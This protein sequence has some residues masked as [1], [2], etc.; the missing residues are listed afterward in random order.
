MTR[1]LFRLPW[2]TRRQ[3]GAD[4]DEELR[5]HLDM[6]VYEL[7]ALG[8]SPDAAGR[9]ALRQ[10]G[11]I[12]DARRYIAGVDLDTEAAHRRTEYM[13]DLRQDVIY[14]ILKLRASPAFTLAI[15]LTL[16]RSG[17]TDTMPEHSILPRHGGVHVP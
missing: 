5:F 1:R 7:R 17:A 8:M 6:R 4:V 10:F 12:E 9:E 3:I 15:V 13:G 11:D 2:R 16:A 14:A